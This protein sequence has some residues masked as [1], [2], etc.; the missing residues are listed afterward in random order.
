MEVV[1]L[2]RIGA[3]DAMVGGVL[4]GWLKGDFARGIRYGAVTAALALSQHGDLVVT[5]PAELETLVES[6]SPDIF[7]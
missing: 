5:T 1:I 7:R 4:H 6:S 3:G 2:D